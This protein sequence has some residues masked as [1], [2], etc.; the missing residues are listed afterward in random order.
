MSHGRISLTQLTVLAQVCHHNELTMQTAA[1]LRMNP[2]NI[3]FNI[4]LF[5][6]T[7]IA[8]VNRTNCSPSIRTQLIQYTVRQSAAVDHSWAKAAASVPPSKM[9]VMRRRSVENN[10]LLDTLAKQAP[11]I[12]EQ[13]VQL[14]VRELKRVT[15][16]WDELYLVG[17]VQVYAETAQLEVK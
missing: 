7:H 4:Y 2:K 9:R 1:V 14:L 6:F 3:T 16:L 11:Q 5:I 13:Q 15:L 17:L 8:Q 12:T 10:A